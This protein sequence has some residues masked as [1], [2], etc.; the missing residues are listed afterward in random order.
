MGFNVI[1]L[2]DA[3]GN[4]FAVNMLAVCVNEGVIMRVLMK[5]DVIVRAGIIG[6]KGYIKKL[7]RCAIIPEISNF[8]VLHM[9]CLSTW[10]PGEP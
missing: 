10:P 8:Y 2:V 4:F 1:P 6:A 9:A 3:G 7:A 5:S